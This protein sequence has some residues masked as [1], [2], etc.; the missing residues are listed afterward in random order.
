MV[1]GVEIV[2]GHIVDCDPATGEVIQHIK[3]S[4]TEEI[5]AMVVKARISQSSWQHEHTLDQRVDLIKAGLKALG[6]KKEELATMI[7]REMGKII[8][9][10]RN[11]VD[12]AT[13]KDLFLEHVASANRPVVVGDA[14]G[15]QSLIVRDAMGVVVVLAP[16]NFPADEILLLSLPALCAGNTVGNRIKVNSFVLK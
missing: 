14:G 4:T 1:Q 8:S 13:N 2:N 6:E 11:E 12:G 9:E 3:C 5:D 7:T 15:A 10:A 16:W